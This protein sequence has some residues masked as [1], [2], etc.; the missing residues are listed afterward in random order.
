MEYQGNS[1]EFLTGI[2]LKSQLRKKQC[3]GNNV[4]ERV[5]KGAP[6]F[7][8]CCIGK[9]PLKF[10]GISVGSQ[11]P[12]RYN[13]WKPVLKTMRLKLSSWKSRQLSIGRRMI[14]LINSVL[15][16]LPLYFFSFFKSPKKA[17]KELIRLQRQ[18]LWGG[19]ETKKRWLGLNGAQSVYQKTKE[20]WEL[21]TWRLSI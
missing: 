2:R 19:D 5:F 10:L 13:A 9:I 21:K 4:E 6:A 18:F 1:Y 7:L 3:D 11:T 8:A 16:S 17:I 20:D 14:T 15:S 12:R